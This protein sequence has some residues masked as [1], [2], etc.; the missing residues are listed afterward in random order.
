MGETL[1][2]DSAGL[3]VLRE[4]L[5]MAAAAHTRR[6][7][8]RLVGESLSKHLP[9]TWFELGWCTD[10]TATS[11]TNLLFSKG[12][13]VRESARSLRGTETFRIIRDGKA[14]FETTASGEQ[15]LVIPLV[16]PDGAPG[17]A[18]LSFKS[19]S[20]SAL[21]S[22]PVLE[23]LAGILAFAQRH[24]RLIERIAKLSSIAHQESQGLREE[25]RKYREAD[26]IVA[27]SKAMRD[28]LEGVDLVARHDTAVLLRGESGTGKELLARRIHRMSR[29]A[30]QSFVSVNC[31]ALP[32]TLVESEL[33]GHERGA[34]TGATGRHRGRFE[35]AHNGTIF[36]D[37]VAELPPSV[38][39]KLL[40]VLQ[41][42]EF[43]RVG[44]EETIRVNVRVLAATNQ[45]LEKMM[46]RGTL[47]ADLFYRLN[48]FPIVIPPLRERREDIPALA[49]ALLA[50]ISQRL[51]CR[52]PAISATA[53]QRLVDHPWRGNV[54]E[55]ANTL[56]RA[57]IVSQGRELEFSELTSAGTPNAGD[58]AE[59]FS[60]GAR[61]TI[62][63]ALKASGGR[64]YGNQ[65]A[66]SRLGIPPSTLQGKMRRLHIK[67]RDYA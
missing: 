25:L 27:R 55:L 43:E 19:S 63:K 42:G 65:G 36:L 21:L 54:R 30:R 34:F 11:A 18:R 53:L 24:C 59:T 8:T 64:I 66:A 51:G 28:V 38:Q 9:I 6:G 52:I 31:G 39:V 5:A 60:E 37:E 40:R 56:E 1:N 50:E 26:G 32:E 67:P 10:E 2:L 4:V 45:P 33:F 29:R 15:I 22:G 41:E 46:E 20:D 61:R 7:M 57:L 16:D 14:R 47:R 13:D 35:R 62:L 17:Y 23:L 12:P 48:V 3:A 58:A 44:G 49:R